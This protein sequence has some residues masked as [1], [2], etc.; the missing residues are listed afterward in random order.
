MSYY[1]MSAIAVLSVLLVGCSSTPVPDPK[2]TDT[3]Y[4]GSNDGAYT[5]GIGGDGMGDGEYFDEAAEADEADEML[6]SVIYFDF[7][8]SAVRAEDQDLL[9]GHAIQLSQNSLH[10]V[11]LEGHA[12]ERGSREYNIG[13]GERR[14]QA[15]RQIL[16][17]QGVNASQIQT[18][19]FGEERPGSMGGSDSDYAQNRRAEIKYTN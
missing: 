9:S 2:P 8:S 16:M 13:L 10:N 11:R 4:G 17:I 3:T 5:S 14:A 7:D 19:S 1:K 15:V 12:D 18:V 6:G